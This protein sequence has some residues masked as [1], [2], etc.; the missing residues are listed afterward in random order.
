MILFFR[1]NPWYNTFMKYEI[2][3][4]EN[5]KTSQWAGGMTTELAIFPQ[6][7][8]YQEQDFIWRLSTAVVEQEESVFTSLSDYDRVLMVLEGDVI[9]AH[10]GQRVARLKAM[11]QDRFDGGVSTKSFGTCRDYNL[12]VRKGSAGYLDVLELTKESA[13]P[14]R[15]EQGGLAKS[16]QAFYCHSGYGVVA[17]GGNSLMIKEGEQLVIWHEASEQASV[18]VMGEGTLIRAQIFYDERILSRQEIPSAKASFSDFVACM[19]LSLTNFRGSQF[20]FPSLKD[21]WYDEDLKDGIRKIERFYLPMFLWIAGVTAFGFYGADRWEPVAVVGVLVGWTLLMMLVI[22]PLLYLIAV[23]KP[24]N[25]HIK[26][27]DAL[28]EYEQGVRQKEQAENPMVHKIEKKYKISGRN[29]YRVDQE[30]A[31]QKRSKKPRA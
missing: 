30:E 28:T 16:C 22:S 8:D 27:L 21:I 1:E 13:V 10:E 25:A 11:E 31:P 6:K 29:V 18:S 23:P 2:Y 15:E 5:F 9:L 4:N 26:K 20:F 3:R 14:E 19:K 7:S 17:F 24:V 12:M